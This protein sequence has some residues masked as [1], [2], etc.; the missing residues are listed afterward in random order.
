MART[1]GQ[2]LK[3]L[4]IMKMLCEHT[5]KDHPL[6]MVEI[7]NRLDE[8]G[9]SAERKSIYDDISVLTEF[10][11]DIEFSKAQPGGYYLASREFELAEVKLLVDSVISS[12]F[13]TAGKT[14]Q[15][16]KKIASLSSL[17][18]AGLMRREVFVPDRI[19]SMNESIYYNVDFIHETILQNQR[20]S[21]KYIT[22]TKSKDKQYRHGGKRY[23]VSPFAMLRDNENYYMIAYDEGAGKIKHYRVDRMDRIRPIEQ[24]RSGEAA[25]KSLDMSSYTTENFG[26]F[27]GVEETVTIRFEDSLID[28]ALDRFGKDTVILPCADGYFMIRVNVVISPQ[29]YGWILALGGQ[30]VIVEPGHACDGIIAQVEAFKIAQE[31]S[32]AK[33]SASY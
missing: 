31:L 32:Y 29:F 1:R 15:L 10:G 14:R 20:L 8:L 13:I 11:Y 5:D 27:N 30:A 6:P 21:F 33:T 22:Y 28:L 16:L 3:M 25:F 17:H 12:K 23:E 9:I 2:K 7:I 24:P 4:Y 18:E 26:M 19:K